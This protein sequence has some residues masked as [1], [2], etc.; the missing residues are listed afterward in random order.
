MKRELFISSTFD[1]LAPSLDR[2]LKLAAQCDF[3]EKL[4]VRIRTSHGEPPE[5]D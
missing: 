3:E 2:L 5:F 4:N 1:R